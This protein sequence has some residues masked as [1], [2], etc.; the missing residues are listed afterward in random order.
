MSVVGAGVGPARRE[1]LRGLGIGQGLPA[2]RE[3]RAVAAAAGGAGLVVREGLLGLGR[4][5]RV[6]LQGYKGER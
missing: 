5:S 1:A 3:G 4:V 2:G 6:N